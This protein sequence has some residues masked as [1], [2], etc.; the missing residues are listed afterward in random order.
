MAGFCTV[1]IPTYNEEKNIV[2]MARRIRQLYPDFYIS[3]MDDNSK[4]RSRELIEELNDPMIRFVTRDPNDRGLAASELQGILEAETD[5]FVTMDCD[6]QHPPEILGEMYARL[7]EGN[8]LCIG[9][10]KDRFALGFV[11]WA[12]S[13]A[14]NLFAD[15]Y[16]FSHGRNMSK[17]VMS[18][19]IAGRT[20]VFVPVIED[21]WPNLTKQGW[22][23]LLDLLR[24]GPKKMKI[25]NV[26]YTFGERAA[27]ES[28][29]S[30]KVVASTLRQCGIV[31][32]FFA[33]IY[34]AVKG[35]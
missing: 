12:G 23:V 34:S 3:F 35:I 11:R 25:A 31:G 5:Y 19:L 27:G 17:D 32:R 20:D 33:R 14:F 15:M 26:N 1:V 21:N 30:P 16:L 7:E 6:F 2:N 28:H 29:I 4:D 8:D 9:V 22:K 18:G 24:Y 13:W 10:R